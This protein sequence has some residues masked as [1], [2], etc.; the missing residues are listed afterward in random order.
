M[1]NTLIDVIAA[2][3]LEE[4]ESCA[5]AECGIDLGPGDVIAILAIL[6]EFSA[7]KA[8]AAQ[9]KREPDEN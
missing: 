8:I 2:E 5:R 9:G 3:L 7:L 6:S 1:S 4:L